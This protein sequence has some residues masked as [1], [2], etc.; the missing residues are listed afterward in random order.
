M[1]F[2]LTKG[3]SVKLAEAVSS[4]GIAGRL[5]RV[6]AGFGWNTEKY[7]GPQDFNLD[8][9]AFM[10]NSSGRVKRSEDFIFYNNLEGDGVILS[11]SNFTGTSAVDK[12][13]VIIDF[14]S[15]PFAVEHIVFTITID[16]AIQHKQSFDDVTDIS[17]RVFDPVTETEFVRY[18]LA[19]V[20]PI[21]T[22]IIV[23]EL[24]KEN[25]EWY[26]R[27]IGTGQTG[28]LEALCDKYGI[29]I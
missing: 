25:D 3:A 20:F 26:I 27:A 19:E 23:A 4:A 2:S 5:S 8:A 1:A 11:E 9:S 18:D 13:Q 16:Q 6:V 29:D 17:F 22:A 7:T 24:Y 21:E 28:G 15:I 10:L 12:E 14:A